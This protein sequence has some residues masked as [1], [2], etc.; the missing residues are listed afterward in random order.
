MQMFDS[1]D[2]NDELDSQSQVKI[3][4]VECVPDIP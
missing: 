1:V 2:E 4:E 3:E